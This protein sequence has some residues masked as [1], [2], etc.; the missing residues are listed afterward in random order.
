MATVSSTDTLILQNLGLVHVIVGDNIARVPAHVLRDD[1]TSAGMLGLVLAAR[2]YDE[3]RGVPFGR[4]AAMRIRGAVTDELRSMD[5]AGRSVRPRARAIEAARNQLASHLGRSPRDCEVAELLKLEVGEV[6][7]TDADVHRASVLSL[8]AFTPDYVAD[9]IP[10]TDCG[11]EQAAVGRDHL[12]ELRAA[13][14]ELP[15]KL[16][17]VIQA[18]YLDGQTM[19]PI[20]AEMGVTESRVSQLRTQAVRRLR[21]TLAA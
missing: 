18:S 11:A 20:A 21:N 16:Q 4:W 13:V 14:A 17:R 8:N 5:W 2:S 7:A 6:E 19:A 15:P 1:L 9:L 10:D 3:T 12:A